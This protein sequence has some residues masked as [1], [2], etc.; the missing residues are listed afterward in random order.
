[1]TTKIQKWGNSS[2]IRIP[3]SLM[4][5]SKLV[6]GGEVVL[7]LQNGFLVVKPKIQK[8]DRKPKY[9]IEEL[10][11]GMTRENMHELVDWGPDVGA[12]ILPPW[13]N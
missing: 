13:E 6:Q 1:M 8:E 10:V 5:G 2:A 4:Q 11:K 12:E 3:K 7:E 9:T